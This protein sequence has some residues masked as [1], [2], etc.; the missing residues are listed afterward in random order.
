LPQG[1]FLTEWRTLEIKYRAI[2]NFYIGLSFG[3]W[4]F[5]ITGK[6]KVA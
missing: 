3:L 1:T 2:I 5:F 6:R 4:L